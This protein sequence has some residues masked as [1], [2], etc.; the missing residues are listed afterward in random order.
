MKRILHFYLNL[1]YKNKLIF[2]CVLVGLIPLILLGVFCYYQ[3]ISLLLG[4]EKTAL[5][6]AAGTAYSSLDYQVQTYE[7][8][9]SYLAHSET[10]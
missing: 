9:I 2:T 10:I 7:N 5:S 1:K 6:L 4:R 3:T 8:L